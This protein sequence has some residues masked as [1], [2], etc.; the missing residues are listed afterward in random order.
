V[1]TEGGGIYKSTDNGLSFQ[2]ANN[3]MPGTAI[4]GDFASMGNLIFTGLRGNSG[5]VGPYLST[6]NGDSW[7]QKTNGI[8]FSPSVNSL[9]V[10]GSDIYAA[11]GDKG[12]FKSTN[13]GESWFAVNNGLPLTINSGVNVVDAKP[14]II[15]AGLNAGEGMYR[16]TNN[17]ASWEYAAGGLPN[18]TTVFSIY[19]RV[20]NAFVGSQYAVYRTNNTSTWYASNKGLANTQVNDF[21]VIGSRI[22]AS[23]YPSNYGYGEG[24]SVTTD[25]GENWSAANGGVLAEYPITSIEANGTTLFAGSLISIYRSTNYGSNWVKVDSNQFGA[26]VEDMLAFNNVIYAA[27]YGNGVRISTNDGINWSYANNGIADG[28]IG[29]SLM[30]KDNNVYLGAFNAVYVTTNNGAS[31]QSRTSGIYPGSEVYALGKSGG[32]IFAGTSSGYYLS[33]NNG[34]SWTEITGDLVP[35]K[36]IY[37]FAEYGTHVYAGSD[38]GVYHS[39]DNG[40]T[41]RRTISGMGV[42]IPTLALLQTGDYLYAGTSYTGVWRRNVSELLS[43]GS[44]GNTAPD[45]YSLEQNYPNPFNPVT[46]IKYSLSSPGIISLKVYDISGKLVAELVNGLQTQGTHTVEFNGSTLSSGVYYYV[47]KAGSFTQT[48]KMI[49]MK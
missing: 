36:R 25:F 8:P 26:G 33:S 46:V 48:K 12:I 40:L 23:T 47:L 5:S 3:G 27:T 35:P 22:F 43:I 34:I 28:T 42:R 32:N 19:N 41:W 4:I 13:T 6:N 49:L 37:S 20:T 44:T 16:S 14:G 24:V 21:A 1:G 2:A 10:N 18:G 29:L 31:W 30:Q 38:S 39:T 45:K 11:I 17:A 7:V 15:Y 9:S